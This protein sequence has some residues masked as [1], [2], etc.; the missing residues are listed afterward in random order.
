MKQYFSFIAS[1]N[2]S[3]PIACAKIQ[4]RPQDGVQIEIPTQAGIFIALSLAPEEIGG[5]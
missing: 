3:I 1:P 4:S 5:H 2:S